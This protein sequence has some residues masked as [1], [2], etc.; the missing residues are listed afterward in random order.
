MKLSTLKYVCFSF[1]RINPVVGC[2]QEPGVSAL[3]GMSEE[4][5]EHEAVQLAN[6][7]DQ[8]AR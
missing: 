1:C 7:I 4:Q 3:E 5:K 6:L 2:Y 8:L